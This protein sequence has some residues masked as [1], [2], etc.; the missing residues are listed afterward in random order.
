[1]SSTAAFP[2]PKN[3]N[4]LGRGP[5]VM[6]LTWTFTSLAITTTLL[7]LYVRKRMGPCLAIEDWLMF[8]AM[9]RPRVV[10][11]AGIIGH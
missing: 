5:M 10:Y 4:D 8:V 7:R 3:P 11:F 2:P 1:M 6:G 9:V